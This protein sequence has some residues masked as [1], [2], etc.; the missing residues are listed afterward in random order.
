MFVFMSSIRL[1]TAPSGVAAPCLS[2]P[3]DHV[4]EAGHR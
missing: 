3:V 1:R 2:A 4:S